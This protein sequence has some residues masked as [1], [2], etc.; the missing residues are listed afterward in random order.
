M[1]YDKKG[2]ILILSYV[3]IA[4]LLILISAYVARSISE[5]R[6]AERDKNST[7]ALYAA[8]AGIDY[9]LDW[10]RGQGSPPA[11]IAPINVPAG[12]TV[13]T[14][15]YSIIIDPD[16]ANPGTYLKRYQ[17]IS[18][19]Q[20]GDTTRVVSYEVQLDTF[21]RFAYFTDTEHFRWFGIRQPVWFVTGDTLSGPVHS[22]D[23]F[24]ISGSPVFTDIVS[25]TDNAI[26]Y[27][28]GGP[29]QDTPSFVPGSPIFG[30]T[31]IDMPSKALDLRTAAVQNGLHLTGPTTV[32]LQSNGTMNVTNAH[33]NWVNENMAL[34]ANGAVFVTG[35]DLSVSGILQGRVS[36][37][38]NRNI[39]ITDNITY[40][41]NP[42]I[43]PASTDMLGLISEVDV[44][45]P[46]SAPFNLTIQA[47]VMA[48]DESLYVDNWAAG[49][50]KGTL[51]I[52]GGL[53]QDN[54]GPVG[55]FNPAT[56][57]KISGYSKN[58]IY[59]PRLLNSPPPY[60]PTTGDYI[61]LSWREQ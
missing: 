61:G 19:G 4:I 40:N 7:A 22:N 47:S 30:T 8:E 25:Q 3:I 54:R 56:N 46:Q 39:I 42:Q 41:T 15:T 18:T 36:M 23:H 6:I 35:G 43:N 17:V 26:T 21:A 52:Y 59:D 49:P 55:T 37:G 38:T 33:N 60:Y 51:T 48:L 20:S 1:N 27:M 53:I 16:N 11:G 58:Y 28:H 31:P 5:W 44:I 13:E 50:P 2:F 9:G 10:L 24:H 45:I 12:P 57:Q 14:G 29:P 34:P 32:S